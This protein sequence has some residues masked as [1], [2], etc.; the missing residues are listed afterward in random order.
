MVVAGALWI[1]L[2]PGLVRP[3][4][5]RLASAAT[6]RPVTIGALDLTFGEGRAVVEARN[7]RVGQT[8]TERVVLSISGER[9]Q[10]NGDGVRFPNGSSVDH[11]RATIELSALGRPTIP[12]VDA[13]GAVLVATR[14]DRADDPDGPPPFARLLAA[15]R[16]LLGLGLE[17]LVV[18]SGHIEYRGLSERQSAGMTAVLESNGGEVSVSGELLV[19]PEQPPLPFEGTVRDPFSDDWRADARLTGD[20]VTMDVIRFL[21]G[22]LEPGPTMRTTLG[23]IAGTA[24]FALAVELGQMR[25]ESVTLDFDFGPRVDPDEDGFSLDGVRFNARA[26]PEPSGWKVSGAI[27]W[28]RL[29]EG[30]DVEPSPF[31]VRWST[32]VPGSL[33]WSTRTIAIPI[34]ARVAENALSSGSS[35][36]P[37]LERFRLQGRID[38]LAST[39]DPGPGDG[40]EGSGDPSFRLNATVSGFGA[41][42]GEWLVSDAGARIEISGDDWRLRFTDDPVSVT[43]PSYRSA[44]YVLTL[45]GEVR[46]APDGPGLALATGGLEVSSSGTSGRIEGRLDVPLPGEEGEVVLDAEVRIEDASLV[47]LG[48][49]LP[50]LRAAAFADWYRRAVRSG[51]LTGG[52]LRIRGDP[53]RIPFPGGNGTFEARGT[54][55]DGELAY[56]LAWPAVRI[57]EASLAANGSELTFQDIR[58]TIFDTSIERGL[59]RIPDMTKPAGRMRISLEGGGP[60]G[61]LLA[62]MRESPLA[63]VPDGAAVPV[64]ADGPTS[65]SVDLDI[66]YGRGAEERPPGVRGTIGLDG[67]AFGLSGRRATLED[68]RGALEFDA[69]SLSGGPLTGRFRGSEVASN[70]EFDRVDGLRIRFSGED[71][72]SWFGIALADLVDL[73]EEETEPWLSHLSGRASWNATFYARAGIVFRSDLRGVAVDLPAPFGKPADAARP[74]EV[75]L[76]SGEREWI[77]DASYGSDTRG[78]FE[79]AEADGRWSLARG[80]VTLGGTRP[81]LPTENHLE[82]AGRL[83]ELDLDPWLA[84]VAAGSDRDTDWLSR[85]GRV[86]IETSGG[87]VFGRSIALQRLDIDRPDDGSGFRVELGGEG[88]AGAIR[89]PDDRAAGEARVHLARLHLGERFAAGDREGGDPTDDGSRARPE[90]WPSF[91]VR[92]DSLRFG[93]IDFGDTRIVGRRTGSGLEFEELKADSSALQL[94]GSGSW[95]PNEDG[96]STTRFNARVDTDDLSRLLSATG[97]DE[98]AVAGG[99]VGMVLDLAWPGMPARPPLERIEGRIDLEARDGHLPRVRVGP[100]GRLLAL[101]SLEALPRVLSLDLSHVVGKGF[102]YDRIIVRMHLDTGMARIIELKISGPSAR[103]E[104]SGSIDLASRQYDQEVAI[105]PRLT[106]SGA[107]LPV[108]AAA[109]PILFGNLLVEKFA[110]DEILLDRLFRLRYR[111]RGPWD[112]PVIERLGESETA[113]SE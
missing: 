15:P 11:F 48:N 35:I 94:R 5:E 59:A 104:V 33:Q 13:T 34:L 8:T 101:L 27:D 7:V 20:R 38:E 45:R 102:T 91:D 109:W 40:P 78:Q 22:V 3:L 103:I 105:I 62:F 87:R 73:G 17:R 47:S 26:V 107:L 12:T 16:V 58:G 113:K 72:P 23:R 74:L 4:A 28:S 63:A 37:R 21:A 41:T 57:D 111:L 31:V 67:V 70:V 44:A 46:V 79:I 66:P 2:D 1:V 6:G 49:L 9:A 30:A 55:R 77:I 95:R 25:I 39:G 83:P 24:G 19:A 68:V 52:S 51:R 43:V 81:A 61:D 89:I 108:W 106:R 96:T 65:T 100:V 92:I 82:V 99:S 93:D 60:A 76:T 10:A 54:I 53:R 98:E 71:E 90:D 84:R 88:V 32:G 69:E 50:D 14:R 85:I 75:I 112:D 36:R 56:A 80:E 86:A 18:H 29:P 64:H 97:L 110:G 42:A